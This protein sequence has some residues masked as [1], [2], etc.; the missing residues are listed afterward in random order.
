MTSQRRRSVP[1][2]TVHDPAKAGR[3]SLTVN[4][5]VVEKVAAQVAMSDALGAPTS[6][7]LGLR[8]GADFDRGPV[9]SARLDGHRADLSVQVALA[10]PTPLDQAC[11]ELRE[12]LR[13][14]VESLSGVP[15]G[16]VDIEVTSIAR[17]QESGPVL[18]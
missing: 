18:A 15:V 10:Y 1:S 11:E 14:K 17:P 6:T 3:G 12:R 4:T 2:L 7:L 13:T 5:K 9:V 16:S 8:K